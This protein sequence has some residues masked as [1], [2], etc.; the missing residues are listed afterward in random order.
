[1]DGVA[2]VVE[3]AAGGAR[4]KHHGDLLGIHLACVEAAERARGGYAA[5]FLGRLE[6]SEAARAGVPGI[7][8]HALSVTGHRGG[9]DGTIAAAVFAREAARVGENVA[10]E[11]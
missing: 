11:V 6:R 2:D 10:A 9:R 7:A 3:Q 5:Y 8:L 1:M 4:F